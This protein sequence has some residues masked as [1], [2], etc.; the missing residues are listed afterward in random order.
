MVK[1]THLKLYVALST[2]LLAFLLNSCGRLGQT[3]ESTL[4][5]PGP[6]SSSPGPD[7]PEALPTTPSPLPTNYYATLTIE[8]DPRLENY[9]FPAEI[10]PE[11]AQVIQ[12]VLEERLHYTA[13]R[14][15]YFTS[16]VLLKPIEITAD[17]RQKAYL[18]AVSREFFVEEGELKEGGGGQIPAALT[19][20]KRLEGWHAEMET[21]LGGSWG[22]RLQEIF[23]EDIL[24]LMSHFPPG[25]SSSINENITH[26]AESH[27]GLVFDEEKNSF[28][29]SGITA[30]PAVVL[31]TLTPTATVD[32]R[33]IT[34]H[35]RARSLVTAN[36]ISI[37]VNLYDGLTRPFEKGLV[38]AD[39][40]V[41]LFTRNA[42]GN[43][44]LKEGLLLDSYKGYDGASGNEFTLGIPL[45][46]ILEFSG[47]NRGLVYQ[48]TDK[49]GEVFWEE[50][51]YLDRDLVHIYYND[52]GRDFPNDYPQ[53]VN[54]GV[55]IGTP[56]LMGNK[57]T[58][59]FTL[60]N[61][62]YTVQEPLGGFFYLAYQYSIT[63]A[64]GITATADLED[65]SNYLVC[66]LHPYHEDGVYRQEEALI[67]EAEISGASGVLSANF[68]H[69]WLD[70]KQGNI[71]QYLLLIHEPA[72]DFFK[73]IKIQFQ[74]SPASQ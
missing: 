44:P 39:W 43:Y 36:R 16:Y 62:W 13:H 70:E 46:N 31:L 30:T 35:V 49:S 22:T 24:P 51:I 15:K 48:V 1:P 14:G 27:Y 59:I 56:N 9:L 50:E 55:L 21:P 73:E 67:L 63:K 25:L 42:D 4:T 2:C 47:E 18:Y 23:P 6:I 33:S 11:I 40:H 69:A 45:E 26:Q 54:E 65:L 38:S 68:P 72:G 41:Y 58:L 53:A 7:Q 8:A 74:P 52:E 64:T 66:E 37:K 12:L 61:D 20:E 3:F 5:D 17:G 57:N 10:D 60:E 34:P 28:P 71:K 32:L 29:P 19:L